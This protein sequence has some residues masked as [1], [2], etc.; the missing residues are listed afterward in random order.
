MTTVN[1]LKLQKKLILLHKFTQ[2]KKLDKLTSKLAYIK[3][4]LIENFRKLFYTHLHR[5]N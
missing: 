1:A 5:L 4:S 2:L 3:T